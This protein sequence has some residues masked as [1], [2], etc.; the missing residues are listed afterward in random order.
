MTISVIQV[1]AENSN[2]ASATTIAQTL[3]FTAGTYIYVFVLRATTDTVTLAS[4]TGEGFS[5]LGTISQAGDSR[6]IDHLV[7]NTGMT[8]GST[9]ITATYSATTTARGMIIVE[10]GDCIG[11]D[12]AA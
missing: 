4:T 5:N 3:T 6:Y 11:Y 12:S 10:I 2:V 9:T 8:G 7:S 1:G